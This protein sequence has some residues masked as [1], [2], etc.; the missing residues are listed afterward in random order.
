TYAYAY[1]CIGGAWLVHMGEFI[2]A[3]P[4]HPPAA[5]RLC[6]L[7]VAGSDRKLGKSVMNCGSFV[8]FPAAFERPRLPNGNHVWVN[9][10]LGELVNVDI[11]A[12]RSIF[13]P[14][15]AGNARDR[16]AAEGA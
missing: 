2:R 14:A 9:A 3:A 15:A 8:T 13:R 16:R 11:N 1:S 10:V 12:Q 6:R 7:N 4:G 5:I